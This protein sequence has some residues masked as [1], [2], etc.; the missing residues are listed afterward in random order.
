MVLAALGGAAAVAR[1][2][3]YRPFEAPPGERTRADVPWP[4]PREFRLPPAIPGI[5]TAA[6]DAQITGWSIAA[7][8]DGHN[9]PPGRGTAREGEEL[10][11]QH[12]ASCHGDFG[13]GLE[14]W[15]ALIGGRNSLRGPEVRRTVG[16]FW[17][18]APAVFD[19]IRRAM[20]YQAPQSLSN[21]EY[22]AI[23][24]YVLY[25]NELVEN[26]KEVD[27]AFLAAIR[28]P[29]R[30][31]FV[32]EARP[33]TEDAACVSNCRQGRPVRVTGDSRRF[34]QPGSGSGFSEPQ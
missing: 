10:Y 20:P 11:L 15:P 23:T 22:Y 31:G 32:L 29:N 3:L 33:D 19:Y 17:Q 9:L 5:G 8:A 26:E 25:L 6:T 16:S 4:A 21:D 18:H 13:E 7:R 12:C 28:M 34:V 27:A 2:D 1:G 24:A 30:D 14:R